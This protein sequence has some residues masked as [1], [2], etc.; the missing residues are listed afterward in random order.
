MLEEIL[1]QYQ[2]LLHKIELVIKK[3]SDYYAEHIICKPGCSSCC[4]VERTVLSL[5][6]Y[7]AEQQLLTLST[8]RIKKLRN[9]HRK[10]DDLC[11]MLWN[12]MCVIYPARPVIC[13]THGLPI[14]Y[15]E[16]EITFVDYCRLNFTK[17]P[18]NYNFLNK[19]VL[20]LTK[21]NSELVQLDQQFTEQVLG[22]QWQPDNR[23]S[24]KRVLRELDTTKTSKK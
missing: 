14:F 10:N 7:V 21:F 2:N 13:R 1:F 24:L 5:E 6:A 9:R 23:I 19:N 16:A 18:E 11:P 22:K 12:K 8:Q 20:D 15:H 3:L 17:L 4:E